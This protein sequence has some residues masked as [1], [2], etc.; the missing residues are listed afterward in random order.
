[1]IILY[2]LGLSSLYLYIGFII[3][4]IKLRIAFGVDSRNGKWRKNPLAYLLFPVR[5]IRNQFPMLFPFCP[6]MRPQNDFKQAGLN[7]YI[8]DIDGSIDGK[9]HSKKSTLMWQTFTWPAFLFWSLGTLVIEVIYVCLFYTV[10]CIAG[11]C[12]LIYLLLLRKHVRRIVT[13]TMQ[14]FGTDKI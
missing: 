6:F 7:L 12:T 9:N 8:E 3:G 13:K 10:S 11:F 4:N 1:M 14:L 5:C 2:V